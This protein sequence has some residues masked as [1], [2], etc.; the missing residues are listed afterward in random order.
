M[1]GHAARAVPASSAAGDFAII[2]N[3]GSTNTPGYRIEIWPTGKAVYTLVRRRALRPVAPDQTSASSGPVTVSAELRPTKQFFADLASA[4][5]LSR[6]PPVHCIKS[7][8]FGYR[9]TIQYKG[10]ESPDLSCPNSDS[11]ISALAADAKTLTTAV[12][13]A[14]EKQAKKS[15][16]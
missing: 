11:K 2:V 9:L 12:Q 4:G 8:S 10:Q 5:N 13:E 1:G 7:V 16:G 14:V 3:S 6:Y 15:S